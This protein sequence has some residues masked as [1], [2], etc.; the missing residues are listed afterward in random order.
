[1]MTDV[2]GYFDESQTA[3]D[4][5]TPFVAGYLSSKSQWDRFEIEWGKLLEEHEIPI[6]PKLG[7]RVPHR[8]ELEWR[9]GLFAGWDR[10]RCDRFLMEA[11]PIIKDSNHTETPIGH[12]VW[13]ADFDQLAADFGRQSF[14]GSYGWCVFC[15][16][17]GTGKWCDDNNH[18]EPVNY[19]FE[20]IS[21]KSDNM[22]KAMYDAM[23]ADDGYR[24]DCRLGTLTFADKRMKQLHAADF[25]A[26]DFG[27][28]IRDFYHQR[29]NPDV[30]ACLSHLLRPP[31]S[32][33][34]KVTWWD[35]GS[36]I[37]F[38]EKSE[39]VPNIAVGEIT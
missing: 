34:A 9:T 39:N 31:K 17:M 20:K 13:R 3:P 21:K 19:V 7:V 10:K 27:R 4:Q 36:L 8:V 24:K 5:Q 28:H 30:Y 14:G 33:D 18:N 1:M 29:N 23:Y 22:V 11:W 16:F 6:D 32:G 35:R 25:F 2:I 26:Y 12:A 37:G 15:C 38:F